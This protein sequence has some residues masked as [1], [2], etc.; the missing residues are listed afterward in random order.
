MVLLGCIL[1]TI[2]VLSVGKLEL[3]FGTILVSMGLFL[4]AVKNPKLLRFKPL[5]FVGEKLYTWIYILHVM[6]LKIVEEYEKRK[7][8]IGNK[9]L[10]INIAI[11]IGITLIIATV[12]YYIGVLCQMIIRHIKSKNAEID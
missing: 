5:E 3:Y 12:I 10:Y 1:T 7:G 8:L 2:E 11:V 4:F 9:T 6:A